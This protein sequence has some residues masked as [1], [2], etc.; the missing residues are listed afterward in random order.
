[1]A[2]AA[3]AR[4]QIHLDHDL[5]HSREAQLRRLQD[6]ANLTSFHMFA[7]TVNVTGSA[8]WDD[9]RD[10]EER[11]AEV[12]GLPRPDSGTVAVYSPFS[13]NLVAQVPDGQNLLVIRR[14][15]PSRN[16]HYPDR[17]TRFNPQMDAWYRLGAA[18]IRPQ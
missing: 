10:V 18:M 8:I 6:W 15:V 4:I 14:L 3:G 12:R 9:L 16:P 5:D 11:R 1:L 17:T 13:A 2:A 7:A